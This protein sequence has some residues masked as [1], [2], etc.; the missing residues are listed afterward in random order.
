VTGNNW[1]RKIKQIYDRISIIKIPPAPLERE[2]F[3]RGDSG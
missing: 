3:Y 1:Q 2:E